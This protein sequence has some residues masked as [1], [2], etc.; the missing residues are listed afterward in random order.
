MSPD[1]GATQV[2]RVPTWMWI[3]R[4]GWRPVSKTAA[5]PGVAVTATATPQRVVWS[6]GNGE[7]VTCAGPGTPYSSRYSASTASPDCGYVYR[8]SSAGQPGEAFTVT[9]TVVWDVVWQGG[10]RGGTIRGLESRS[11]VPV[12]VTEVQGVVV[13]R[14]GSI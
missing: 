13:A 11:E 2:V 12:R 5:V 7:S 4:A 1:A 9:A 10:G 14:S 3:D 6:M 8:R